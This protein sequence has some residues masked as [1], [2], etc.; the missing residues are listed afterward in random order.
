M[1]AKMLG[2]N[3]ES[4]MYNFELDVRDA[5]RISLCLLVCQHGTF[6]L[7]D[8]GDASARKLKGRD[9]Y[10]FIGF[11]VCC[12]GIKYDEDVRQI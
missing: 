10:I 4:C 11:L 7:R 2:L 12:L 3:N 9:K 5:V 1:R 8:R 6:S